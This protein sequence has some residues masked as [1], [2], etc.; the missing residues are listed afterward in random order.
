MHRLAT[1]HHITVQTDDRRNTVPIARPLV[2]SAKNRRSWRDVDQTSW[3][4]S[5]HLGTNMAV[6]AVIITTTESNHI[7]PTSCM[8]HRKICNNLCSNIFIYLFIYL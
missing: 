7:Q 1:I 4:A 2:R 6:R 3:T 8:K 5:L